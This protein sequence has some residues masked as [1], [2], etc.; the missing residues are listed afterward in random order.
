MRSRRSGFT[1][2]ETLVAIGLVGLL[3]ALALPA[4]QQ[5]REAARRAS[6]LNNLRQIGLAV[7]AYEASFGVYPTNVGNP[8]TGGRGPSGF[9]FPKNYSV[10]TQLLPQL[11]Q[12]PLYNAFN[13]Q[14][15]L[16]SPYHP[17]AGGQFR[18]GIEVNRTVLAAKLTILVCPSDG[19]GAGGPG[20]TGGVNY[21]VNLGTDRWHL[22][23]GPLS[24]MRQYRSGAAVT[25]G[26]SYTVAFSERLRGGNEAKRL[27]PRRAM[28]IGG[29]GA[30]YSADESL[31]ACIAQ[32]GA[33]RGFFPFAGLAWAAGDHGQTCYNHILEPNSTV[34][35]CILA[36]TAGAG[37]VGARSNHPGGVHTALADGSARWVSNTITRQ[38]WRA[39]GTRAGREITGQ[40]YY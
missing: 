32:R 24:D 33:P 23:Q 40:G 27:D 38:T 31:A 18:W 21:R 17:A 5:A 3:V 20:W 34:P 15:P 4:V 26:L 29:L 36:P 30:P 14:V 22:A 16:L 28:I 35:D 12:V 7:Q 8:E 13:F 10:F 19:G 9:L 11:D 6:C 1:L 25:D 2:I 37:I 39:L